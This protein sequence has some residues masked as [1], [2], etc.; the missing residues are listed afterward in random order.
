MITPSFMIYMYNGTYNRNTRL[1]INLQQFSFC[2]IDN[3]KQD[4][5]QIV[6]SN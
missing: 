1:M 5:E 3:E 2:H 4:G 6:L